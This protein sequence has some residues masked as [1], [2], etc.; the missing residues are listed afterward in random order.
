MGKMVDIIGRKFNSLTVLE[1]DIFISRN[2]IC[3]CDC[4]AEKSI[5]RDSVVSGHTKSCGCLKKRPKHE[6]LTGH[7]FGRLVVISEAGNRDNHGHISWN[8]VCD[9]GGNRVVSGIKLRMGVVVSCGC[10]NGFDLTGKVFGRLTVL[11]LSGSHSGARFWKCRCVCGNESEVETNKLT[12]SST[13]SCGCLVAD[14]AREVNSTHGMSK[15]R[16]YNAW[17]SAKERCR[18]KDNS[19]FPNYGGRGIKMCDEW[20]NSFESFLRDMGNCPK[21][22]SL[23]RI[24]VDGDYMP[25]N[26]RWATMKQQGNNKRNNVRIAID[27]EEKT[28]SEWCEER[29]LCVGTVHSRIKDYG[30]SPEEAITK[31]IGYYHKIYTYEGR[32]GTLADWA[33]WLGVNYGTLRSRAIRGASLEKIL[34]STIGNNHGRNKLCSAP[35]KDCGK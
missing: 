6:D 25:G 18:R 12:S 27:G 3:K 22:M 16:E 26:C 13:R 30:F 31:P 15:S 21:G 11:G 34:S 2:V 24:D 14:R 19:Q 35:A 4:G 8:C 17:R 33:R 23:D 7:R 32:S 28:M 9:C 5:A 1:K 10:I 29:D 20:E